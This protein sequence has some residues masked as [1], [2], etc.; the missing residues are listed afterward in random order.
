[1]MMPA[2]ALTCGM[3]CLHWGQK[4]VWML[5]LVLLRPESLAPYL[6]HVAGHPGCPQK[7]EVCLTVIVQAA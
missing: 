1:M 7:Y 6:L 5:K 4:M 3:S 2:L